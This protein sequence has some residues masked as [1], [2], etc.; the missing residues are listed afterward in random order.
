MRR[1]GRS[2]SRAHRCSTISGAAASSSTQHQLAAADFFYS[3]RVGRSPQGYATEDGYA[4][5]PTA[6]RSSRGQLTGKLGGSWN[7]GWLN[8]V[9]GREFAEIDQLGTRL[10]Q[11]I[12]PLTYYG[13][14]RVQKDIGQAG[15]G[16]G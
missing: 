13:A 14:L 5:T 7:V 4:R 12:E 8:A 2:S 9:T 3:R 15:A 11:E 16:S 10:T 1:S 6:R